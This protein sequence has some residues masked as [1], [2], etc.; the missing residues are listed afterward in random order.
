MALTSGLAATV[1]TAPRGSHA[2]ITPHASDRSVI[3][4]ATDS[5]VSTNPCD[6]VP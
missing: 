5:I 4:P 1:S 2:R 3:T 6:T